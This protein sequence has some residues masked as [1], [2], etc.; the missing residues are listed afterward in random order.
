MNR[1]VADPDW[2]GYIVAYFYLGG[3]AAGAYAIASMAALFGDEA[4]RRGTRG[5]FY[6]AFPIVNF[7][8]L[9]LTI[10]LGRPERFWHMMFRSQTLWPM[11]KWWS[12][13][14]A[15]AWGL[16]AFG[17]FSGA[18]FLGVLA[19][20]R[21]FGLGRF[22]PIA[23]RLG[24]GFIGRAFEVGGTLSAFFLGSYTGAL[25]TAT[26]QPIWADTSWLAAL[27]LASS[28]STGIAALTLVHR[29]WL[30][31]AGREVS[32]RLEF[33]DLWAI[34]LEACTLAL[35][36]MSMGRWIGLALSAWPGI[37]LPAVVVP[38][39]LVLPALFL[40]GPRRVPEW[41]APVL[42]LVGGFFLRYAVVGLPEVFRSGH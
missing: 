19:E 16:A 23:E 31:D 24:R 36:A 13:M 20:D 40:A 2:H 22:A 12:P 38:V 29:W 3:I 17:A 28:A 7:C 33:A 42:V 34:G 15:G 37:L 21:R 35:F 6:I 10:D 14:S 18:S 9:L 26:N 1:F 32:H 8:G 30:G 11:F 39:G 27:F 25:L 4:A 41:A 5:A